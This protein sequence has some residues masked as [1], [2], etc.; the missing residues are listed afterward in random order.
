M[1]HEPAP[2][3]LE[4]PAARQAA[5]RRFDGKTRPFMPGSRAAAYEK[6]MRSLPAFVIAFALCA[7]PAAVEAA[8]A[9]RV[10]QSY[11]NAKW[12][13]LTPAQRRELVASRKVV[14]LA[15]ALRAVRDMPEARASRA[16]S[17]GDIISAR[18]CRGPDGLVYRLTVLARD[19]K[20][21]RVAVDAVTGKLVG[22]E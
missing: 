12:V 1:M 17:K 13:C 19:G 20:V 11:G 18:L 7:F 9:A 10:A 2:G 15:T 16:R 14:P 3:H 6:P 4:F 8:P 5:A 21:A 22:G